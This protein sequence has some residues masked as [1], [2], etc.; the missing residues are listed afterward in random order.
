ML[1]RFEEETGAR[2]PTE[3]EELAA[4]LAEDEAAL[5]EVAK[6]ATKQYHHLLVR[7][8]PSAGMMRFRMGAQK[9]RSRAY[10][11]FPSEDRP[12][13]EELEEQT[14]GPSRIP[15]PSSQ[16]SR[17]PVYLAIAPAAPPSVAALSKPAAAP[18]PAP[19][20]TLT[21][22][23]A[24]HLPPPSKPHDH[25]QAGSPPAGMRDYVE[26]VEVPVS[27]RTVP[28]PVPLP[29]PSP[30]AIAAARAGGSLQA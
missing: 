6:K 4:K 11:L 9:H 2:P 17:S 20:S 29:A 15:V 7:P 1:A 14:V 16:G 5:G 13:I 27:D 25:E 22:Q 3:E 26:K 30:A 24:Q 19:S 12:G 18:T 21:Q 8:R 10:P 23:P 28:L